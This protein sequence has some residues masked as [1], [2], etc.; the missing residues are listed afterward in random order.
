MKPSRA[1]YMREWRAARRSEFFQGRECALCGSTEGLELDHIDPSTKISS[2]V[3]FW[4]EDR[5]R[6]ELAKCQALC[7]SCHK[8]KSRSDVGKLTR[9][10]VEE[11]RHLRD[12]QGLT[13]RDLSAIY[14]VH[15]SQISRVINFKVWP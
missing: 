8:E 15:T 11:I 14:G 10:Q 7:H 6:A 5:R 2:H 12:T 3:W 4:S 13:L 9:Q 1:K